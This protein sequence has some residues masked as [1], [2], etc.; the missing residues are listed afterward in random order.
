MS[1]KPDALTIPINAAKKKSMLFDFEIGDTTQKTQS[2][3]DYCPHILKNYS[4]QQTAEHI[5]NAVIN[6]K[7]A[8]VG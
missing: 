3:G 2:A 4:T 6:I 8:V 5:S 7:L 1:A